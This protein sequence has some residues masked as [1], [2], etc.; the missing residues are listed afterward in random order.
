MT[1]AQF[2]KYSPDVPVSWRRR[3]ALSIRDRPAGVSGIHDPF[4]YSS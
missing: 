4:V 1:I 3:L 2:S